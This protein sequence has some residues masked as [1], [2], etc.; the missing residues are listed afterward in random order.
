M[1]LCS[2]FLSY[3]S[4]VLLLL[5]VK[6]NFHHVACLTSQNLAQLMQCLHRNVFITSDIAHGMTADVVMINQTVC[7]Y[8]ALLHSAPKRVVIIHDI[9]L[10]FAGLFK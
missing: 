10:F 5:F 3:F 2:F 6:C 1:R 7:R 4:I 8:P 9:S